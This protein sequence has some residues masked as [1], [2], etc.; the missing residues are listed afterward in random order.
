M[1]KVIATACIRRHYRS[2]L[3]L[4][5]DCSNSVT[6]RARKRLISQ[7]IS[8]IEFIA[9]KYW[10][11]PVFL[12]FQI[13]L[14]LILVSGKTKEFLFS[15]SD[16]AGDIAHHVFE[17]W[18]EGTY[19]WILSPKRKTNLHSFAKQR[20]TFSHPPARETSSPPPRRIRERKGI[21]RNS[22]KLDLEYLPNKW[23]SY[24]VLAR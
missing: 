18:P 10:R 3:L 19:Y 7:E 15:P 14:R 21:E 5:H 2:F 20:I 17:N 16:S 13:N 12:Y 6:S 9:Y 4:L 8:Q 1:D 24:S 11:T 22:R 23:L